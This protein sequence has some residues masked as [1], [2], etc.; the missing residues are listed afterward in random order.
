MSDPSGDHRVCGGPPDGCIYPLNATV[1]RPDGGAVRVL[2]QPDLRGGCGC[3]SVISR[4]GARWVWAGG[5]ADGPVVG[6]LVTRFDD[7]LKSV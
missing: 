3:G 6:L 4:P 1:T 2:N 5:S 7:C